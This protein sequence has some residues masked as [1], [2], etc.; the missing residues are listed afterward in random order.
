MMVFSSSIIYFNVI[1][2]QII[3]HAHFLISISFLSHFIAHFKSNKKLN[4]SILIDK[5]CHCEVGGGKCLHLQRIKVNT[6]KSIIWG[7]P[8]SSLFYTVLIGQ[9]PEFFLGGYIL[10]GWIRLNFFSL[11]EY[12]ILTSVSLGTLNMRWV[13][14]FP[15]TPSILYLSTKP[16]SEK[17]RGEEWGR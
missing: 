12:F 5:L 7:Y 8:A 9:D 2:F 1:C 11:L 3:L 17:R 10:F 13:V 4:Y 14:R 16:H 6:G 15:P